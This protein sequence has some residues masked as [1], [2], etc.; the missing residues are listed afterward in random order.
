MLG[1]NLPIICLQ[2]IAALGDKGATISMK[3]IF[4]LENSNQ[5]FEKLKWEYSLLIEDDENPYKSYN[6]FVTAWH[7]LEWQYPGKEN[8]SVRTDIKKD[9][10]ILQV[11]EHL[12]IGAKHF[13]PTRQNL[14]SVGSSGKGGV[15]A[16]G[17]WAPGTWAEGTWATWLEV[18][19]ENEAALVF[20]EV[21]KVENLAEKVMAYWEIQIDES[22]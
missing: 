8:A 4:G 12:A 17:V 11:C 3:G 15:W 22:N 19:L 20:G 14:K 21:I 5:L 7:L 10:V 13:E 9:N 6:F 18:K 16:D 1:Q 2:Q